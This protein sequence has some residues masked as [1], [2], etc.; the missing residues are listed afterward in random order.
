MALCRF[1][2]MFLQICFLIKYVHPCYKCLFPFRRFPNMHINWLWSFFQFI[3]ISKRYNNTVRF[4]S[5]PDI[6]FGVAVCHLHLEVTFFTVACDIVTPAY[7]LQLCK[8]TDFELLS[9]AW[10]LPQLVF[11]CDKCL[12]YN[13]STYFKT[14]DV[15]SFTEGISAT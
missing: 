3:S 8:P 13:N 15:S 1:T 9:K 12:T 4:V 11:V 2:N 5:I 10:M 7:I 6:Q 14:S